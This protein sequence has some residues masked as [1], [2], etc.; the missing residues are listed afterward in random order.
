MTRTAIGLTLLAMTLVP[1]CSGSQSR[2][3]QPMY[4]DDD[5]PPVAQGLTMEQMEE[6][7]RVERIGQTAL[8]ECY[9]DELQRRGT[10]KLEGNVAFNILIGTNGAAQ[11]VQITESSLNAPQ[12]QQCMR[13]AIMRWEFPSPE[14]P[15]WYGTS[16]HFA[17]AY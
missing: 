11:Q 17:P 5:T 14:A 2:G 7:K 1:G 10:K 4:V 3:G 9:T 6:I 8:T 13:Q 16:F 15:T 12:A